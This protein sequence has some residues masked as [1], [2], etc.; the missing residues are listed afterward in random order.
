MDEIEKLTERI[1]KLESLLTTQP[2][3]CPMC[4]GT[5]FCKE[6]MDCKICEGSGIVWK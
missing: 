1:A 3:V 4:K 6:D 5:T 2:Y